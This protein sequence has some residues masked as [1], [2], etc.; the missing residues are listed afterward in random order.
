MIT[1]Y[2]LRLFQVMKGLLGFRIGFL[3]LDFLGISK[4]DDNLT[5]IRFNYKVSPYSFSGVCVCAYA[6]CKEIRI[7]SCQRFRNTVVG[8]N[9]TA[10][11]VAI[12]FAE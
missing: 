11:V 6:H 4:G 12:A 9:G 7:P 8:E 10:A 3:G 2:S 5:I 1:C